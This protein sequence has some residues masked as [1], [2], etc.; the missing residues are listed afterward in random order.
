[1]GV[2]RDGVVQCVCKKEERREKNGAR[3]PRLSSLFFF[4][5]SLSLPPHLAVPGQQ[6]EGVHAKAFHVAVVEGD[7]DIVQQEG[8]HVHGWGKE[9]KGR[10]GEKKK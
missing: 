5:L 2:G 6:G 8:E 1:M 3:A 4:S 10:E 7:A 9:E